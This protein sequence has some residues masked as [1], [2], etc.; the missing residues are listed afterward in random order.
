MPRIGSAAKAVPE[1][2][3]D[4]TCQR[5]GAKA[6]RGATEKC[7][8]RELLSVVLIQFGSKV[9]GLLYERVMVSWR[10]KSTR[11]MCVQAASS[12]LSIE[13]GTG[14]MPVFNNA[15]AEAAFA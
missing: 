4:K 10:F 15:S 13:G 8:A 2:E 14:A 11:A 5:K 9:H 7:P 6:L 1:F 12:A 3:R